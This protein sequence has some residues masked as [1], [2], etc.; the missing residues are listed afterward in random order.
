MATKKVTA[1]TSGAALWNTHEHKRA[2]LLGLT[3][4]NKYSA[5]ETVKLHDCFATD[6]SKV[7]STG[8][9]QAVEYLGVS[10]CASG[11]IRLQL[12]VPA[13]ESVKLGEEDCRGVEFLGKA[14]AVSS[15]TTSD[16]VVIA[17][18]KLR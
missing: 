18:Y 17:Q 4:D 1:S 13:G 11:L 12:T 15:A 8:A 7:D 6:A 2:D 16:C 14:Y 5:A 9:T 3:I 10:G